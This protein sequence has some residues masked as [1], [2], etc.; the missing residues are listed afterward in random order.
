MPTPTSVDSEEGSWH[1][2]NRLPEGGSLPTPD[3]KTSATDNISGPQLPRHDS[4]STREFLLV[5]LWDSP[6]EE[7][8]VTR[9]RG[10]EVGRR[11]CFTFCHP[12]SPDPASAIPQAHSHLPQ[13]PC[14]R[15]AS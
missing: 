7:P 8:K 12:I 11:T 4:E 9:G 15:C 10:E 2:F 5:E 14:T 13:A 6:T 3:S 1:G